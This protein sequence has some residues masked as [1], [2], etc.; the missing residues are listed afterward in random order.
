MIRVNRADNVVELS[1]RGPSPVEFFPIVQD[2]LHETFKRYPGLEVTRFTPCPCQ[3]D[4]ASQCPREYELDDLRIAYRDQRETVEC[5]KFGIRV[6]V[7]ELLYG[8]SLGHRE[9]DTT[10]RALATLASTVGTSL[11]QIQYEI[12][13]LR[14]SLRSYQETRCPS[15][16]SLSPK[17][18][19]R[20]LTEKCELRL[21]CEMPGAWHPL[22][23]NAGVYEIQEPTEL[24]KKLG[25]WLGVLLKAFKDMP[26]VSPL[27]EL[28]ADYVDKHRI[29]LDHNSTRILGNA[30]VESFDDWYRAAGDSRRPMSDAEFRVLEALLTKLDPNRWWGGLNPYRTP[31]G[32]V[33]YLCDAHLTEYTRGFPPEG[34]VG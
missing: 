20:G 7:T 10:S 24:L 13:R 15:V 6:P 12:I 9:E 17:A 28:A 19:E 22:D 31:E 33:L 27:M 3:Q 14:W 21:F 23:G 2:S 25:P 34:Q 5:H 1:A 16:F 29:P 18:A 26:V 11:S 32:P 8:M 4:R 30:P